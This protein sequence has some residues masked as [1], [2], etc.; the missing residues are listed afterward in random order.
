MKP[1]KILFLLVFLII[2][3]SCGGGGSGGGS[4]SGGGSQDPGAPKITF[5]IDQTNIKRGSTVG[6]TFSWEDSDG[7]IQTIYNR[8]K[9]SSGGS[10]TT[11]TYNAKD[12]RVVGVSGTTR[13]MLATISSAAPGKWDNDIWVVDAKGLTSNTVSFSINL[14]VMGQSKTTIIEQR[15]LW[16][17]K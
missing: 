16:I 10:E 7:D 8:Q 2:I 5:N 6:A 9:Y 3:V 14:E 15:E 1:L 11:K 4:S 17:I 12:M 13:I